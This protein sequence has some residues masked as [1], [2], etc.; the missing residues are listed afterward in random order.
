MLGAMAVAFAPFFP[1]IVL[2]PHSRSPPR[3]LM[4]H[5]FRAAMPRSC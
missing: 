4:A 3:Y 1:R 5:R 2:D